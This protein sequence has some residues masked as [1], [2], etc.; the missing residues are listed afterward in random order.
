MGT[1]KQAKNLVQTIVDFFFFCLM[2]VGVGGVMFKFLAPDG[3]LGSLTDG[4]MKM[5]VGHALITAVGAL[6]AL[7]LAKRWLDGFNMKT[8]LGDFIMYGW[9]LLG[10]YFGFR[11]IVT[12][13]F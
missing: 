12:G 3:W 4:L 6:V 13:S 2:V 11:Y 7:L 5:G 9:M 1:A 10:L 8:S